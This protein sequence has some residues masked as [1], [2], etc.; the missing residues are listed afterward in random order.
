MSGKLVCG[1]CG[2]F[3]GSKVWHSNTPNRVLVWQCNEK[4]R[5]NG[6]RTPHLTERETQRALKRKEALKAIS[7]MCLL[8]DNLMALVFD[9]N[10]EATELLLNIILQRSDQPFDYGAN[11]TYGYYLYRKSLSP[12]QKKHR[13][14]KPDT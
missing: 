10:P 7:E 11:G 4:H 8:G 6:Y 12:E 3:Y 9:R 14:Q 2:G 13:Y 5:G 1:H